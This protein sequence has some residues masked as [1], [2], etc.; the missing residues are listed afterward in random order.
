VTYSGGD[1]LTGRVGG[2]GPRYDS[3]EVSEGRHGVDSSLTWAPACVRT[4]NAPVGE[5]VWERRAR[6]SLERGG[7]S[8]EGASSP[9]ARRSVTRGGVQPS[10]EAESRSRGRPTLRRGG[11]SLVRCCVPRAKRSFARGAGAVCSGGPLRPPGPW[12]PTTWP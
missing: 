9:R 1:G 10:S 12:A 8:P 4:L 3:Q 6:E 5:W 7:V 2:T 11:V